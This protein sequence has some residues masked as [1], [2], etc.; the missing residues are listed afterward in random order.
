MSSGFPSS[1]LYQSPCSVLNN[2]AKLGTRELEKEKVR[3]GLIELMLV[4]YVPGKHPNEDYAELQR[5]RTQ[6]QKLE[7]MMRALRP[8]SATI[9][10]ATLQETIDSYSATLKE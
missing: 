5:L 9:T 4:R 7:I 10:N 1:S 6:N 2:M 8:M 3:D